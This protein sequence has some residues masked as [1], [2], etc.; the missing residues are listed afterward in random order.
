MQPLRILI[1]LAAVSGF[2]LAR[3]AAPSL[4][5]MPGYA[6]PDFKNAGL[7]IILVR[8]N[9]SIGDPDEFAS[10]FG[11]G[12]ATTLFYSCFG[13]SFPTLIRDRTRFGEVAFLA[14]ADESMRSGSGGLESSGGG[15]EIAS[16]PKRNFVDSRYKFL[17]IVDRCS[18]RYDRNNGNPML[19]TEGN[20][21]G[22]GAGLDLAKMSA[23]FMLWDNAKAT[24]VAYGSVDETLAAGGVFTKA[25][26]GE[27]MRLAAESAAQ[28][29]PFGK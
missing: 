26:L 6:K 29:M 10:I 20:F 8:K 4:T 3:C 19:G 24:M 5:L 15:G 9:C 11:G 14:G 2:F 16:P 18:I 7:G 25:T 28:G 13:D 21:T 23:M 12:D 17:L 1:V 27:L 22:I